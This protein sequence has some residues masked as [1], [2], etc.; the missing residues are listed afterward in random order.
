MFLDQRICVNGDQWRNWSPWLWTFHT[1]SLLHEYFLSLNTCISAKKFVLFTWIQCLIMK[2][3]IFNNHKSWSLL[4]IL[5]NC[6]L[7]DIATCNLIFYLNDYVFT[8]LLL[9]C[10]QRFL[11][12]MPFSVYEVICVT[13]LLRG[14]FVYASWETSAASRLGFPLSMRQINNSLL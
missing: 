5:M 2:A 3:R 9:P 4:I 13:C 12:C 10:E 1:N 8:L 7:N 14:Q 11:S 6:I